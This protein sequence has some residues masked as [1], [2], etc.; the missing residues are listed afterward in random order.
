MADSTQTQ[1]DADIK[2]MATVMTS[3]YLNLMSAITVDAMPFDDL[4]G[5]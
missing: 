4:I 2:P 5:H 3:L 1:F